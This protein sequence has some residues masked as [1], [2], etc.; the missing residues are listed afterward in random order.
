MLDIQWKGQVASFVSSSCGNLSPTH[1]CF[2]SCRSDVCVLWEQ[3]LN[4]I[5][6]FLNLCGVSRCSCFSYPFGDN[7]KQELTKGLACKQ[8]S[9][10]EYM[11]RV[12]QCRSLECLERSRSVKKKNILHGDKLNL[13]CWLDVYKLTMWTVK[14][15]GCFVV[16]C[17]NEIV[18]KGLSVLSTAF[19]AST[20]N[21]TDHS[22]TCIW[23]QWI[24]QWMEVLSS[25][26][27]S[28][29]SVCLTL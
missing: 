23:N 11:E 17:G 16:S 24:P 13:G 28:T 9:V 18:C 10:T 12:Q 19:T 1:F 4:T 26:R 5:P 27:L 20:F 2:S 21:K 3:N 29:L 8:C 22:S 7:L 14:L 15:F 6:Q 25:N